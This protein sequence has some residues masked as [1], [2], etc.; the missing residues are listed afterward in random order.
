VT[1]YFLRACGVLDVEGPDRE[2]FL[3]G[4]L[5]QDVR[6][7]AP[8]EARPTAG[9]TARG[10]LLYL[11]RI[12]G[13]EDRIRILVPDVSH[14]RVVAHLR[15]YAA[16]QKVTVTD[17]SADYSVVG[18]YPGPLPADVF[19]GMTALAGEAEF[20]AEVVV[21]SAD[22]EAFLGRMEAAG[23][24]VLSEPEAEVRRVAAGRPRFGV[25]AGEDTFPGELG[26]EEAI[27][28][29]KGCYVGQEI[30][31]RMK[32]YGKVP[33]RLVGFR[34]P[35]GP[36]GAG[37]TLKR[38]DQEAPGKIEQG[39]VTSSVS[40]PGLG[41]IGLGFAFREVQPGDRLVSVREPSLSAI[42]GPP[43]FS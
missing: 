36:I 35:D 28:R 33:R 11:A 3:Q 32:T 42:V 8:G 39:R 16:F 24:R 7:L 26:I 38:P 2:S 17:R 4:Q 31:A 12:V 20:A 5:T 25:E 18:I 15:K 21:P 9:L 43:R 30:V 1:E 14:E 19:Q 22:R 41:P 23:A 10:K 37:E 6:G 29:T 13:A 34:F 40:S 27:S